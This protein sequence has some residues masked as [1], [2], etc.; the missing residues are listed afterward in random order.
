MKTKLLFCL[1]LLHAAAAQ[2]A[3]RITAYQRNG[4]ALRLSWTNDAATGYYQVRWTGDL[5]AGDWKAGWTTLQHFGGSEAQYVSAEV[6]LAYRVYWSETA[7]DV[8]PNVTIDP[9]AETYYPL[10]GNGI[11]SIANVQTGA[12]YAVDWFDGAG[13]VRGW[14][15]LCSIAATGLQASAQVPLIMRLAVLSTNVPD[16]PDAMAYIFGGTYSYGTG[17]DVTVSGFYMDK[18]EVTED[19]WQAVLPWALTNGY[20]FSRT[21]CYALSNAPVLNVSWVDAAK[22]CNARS[23]MEGYTPCYTLTGGVCRSGSDVPDCVLSNSGYRLPT[24]A[25]WERAARG[26]IS[27]GYFPWGGTST[28]AADPAKANYRNSGDLSE[29]MANLYTPVKGWTYEPAAYTEQMST[30]MPSAL[31]FHLQQYCVLPYPPNDFGLYDMAGNA[32][33]WCTDWYTH[34]PDLSAADPAGPD[35]G[36]RKVVRGGNYLSNPAQLGVARRSFAQPTLASPVIGFRCV[37]NLE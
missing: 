19:Q 1:L 16:P 7:F 34:A 23:E 6:P 36:T 12:W 24:E 17:T 28:N 29:V 8:E 21:D 4:D 18:T 5:A 10:D 20:A 26:F 30:M 25:E 22:W 37:R 13:W 35:E 32:A 3:P 33:E 2:A 31:L 15:S 9:T 11:V 14:E 27:G